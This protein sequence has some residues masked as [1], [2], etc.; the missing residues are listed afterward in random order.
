MARYIQRLALLGKERWIG[1]EI[2]GIG[3]EVP[4]LVL[5]DEI[6]EEEL[7]ERGIREFT[8]MPFESFI[9]LGS[10]FAN[11]G[12]LL[13]QD[14]EFRLDALQ[15]S[16]DRGRACGVTSIPRNVLDVMFGEAI[17]HPRVQE[18]LRKWESTGAVEV[19]GDETCYLRVTGRLA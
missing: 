8:P 7:C 12:S 15:V 2:D 16:L 5:A 14:I 11:A 4:G 18:R 13:E 10:A 19:I 3:T 9:G 6:P 17:E 1:W